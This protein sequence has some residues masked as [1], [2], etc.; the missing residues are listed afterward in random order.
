M[1]TLGVRAEVSAIVVIFR[2]IVKGPAISF[3]R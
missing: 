2:E 1:R 3:D